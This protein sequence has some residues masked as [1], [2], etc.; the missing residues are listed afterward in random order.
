MTENVS[1]SYRLRILVVDDNHDTAA[2]LSALLELKGHRTGTAYN[3]A[4]AVAAA[5]RVRYDAVVLDLGMPLMDGF[6]VATIL[7]QLQPAPRLIAYSAWDDAP[8]RRRTSELGFC[9]H[10]T[11]PVAFKVLEAALKEGYG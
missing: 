8:T 10:L 7:R 11:K 1:D 9:A 2:S 3:G 6:Q 5:T 4:D